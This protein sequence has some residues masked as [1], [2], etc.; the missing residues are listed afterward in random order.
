MLGQA[1]IQDSIQA[2]RL[3]GEPLLG[4]GRLTLVEA[5][6]MVRLPQ[7]RAKP[8]HLPHQPFQ[9]TVAGLALAREELPAF[10]AR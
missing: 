6:E 10:S 1:A 5:Q 8:A 4:V 7:H 3:L 9:D 2:V